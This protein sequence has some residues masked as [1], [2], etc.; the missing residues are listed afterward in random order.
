MSPGLPWLSYNKTSL[1]Y[2]GAIFPYDTVI[3][4]GGIGKHGSILAKIVPFAFH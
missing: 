4:G 1:L 3:R 2:P